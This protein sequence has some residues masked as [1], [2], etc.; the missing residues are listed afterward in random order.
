MFLSSFN[1]TAR[2]H[3]S[4]LPTSHVVGDSAEILVVYSTQVVI[5]LGTFYVFL[6]MLIF[7]MV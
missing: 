5:N 3:C 2:V 1:I 7:K 6:D 4:P